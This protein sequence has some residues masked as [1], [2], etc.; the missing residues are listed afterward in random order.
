MASNVKIKFIYSFLGSCLSSQQ[1]I[2]D[3]KAANSNINV[4]NIKGKAILALFFLSPLTIIF[5]AF[6]PDIMKGMKKLLCLVML[7]LTN[8]GQMTETFTPL[9]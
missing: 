3:G 6:S 1:A 7:L 4:Y 2:C 8:P 9:G 5:A